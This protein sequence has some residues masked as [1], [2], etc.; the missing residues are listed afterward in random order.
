MLLIFRSPLDGQYFVNAEGTYSRQDTVP[1]DFLSLTT[2]LR[3]AVPAASTCSPFIL[4]SLAR[5]REALQRS[6][7]RSKDGSDNFVLRISYCDPFKPAPQ[8]CRLKDRSLMVA[9]LS[10]IVPRLSSVFC[11]KRL[12][13]PSIYLLAG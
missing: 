7:V 3:N 9:A 4:L 12:A 2:K 13:S 11:F 10:S 8:V 6:E 1:L 5:L